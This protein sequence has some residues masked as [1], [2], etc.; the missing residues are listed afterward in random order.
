MNCEDLSKIEFE[1]FLE[2]N[3]KKVRK[4]LKINTKQLRIAYAV[5]KTTY[6]K[7]PESQRLL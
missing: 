4:K 3:L 1:N 2:D 5:E 6:E 7:S